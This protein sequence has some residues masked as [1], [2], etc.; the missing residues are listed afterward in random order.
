M[1]VTRRDVLE[2]AA[3]VVLAAPFVAFFVASGRQNREK[4]SRMRSRP[5]MTLRLATS[6]TEEIGATPRGTLSIFPVTGG[7]FDGNRLRGRVLAGG[8]D[9]VTTRA[10]GVIEVDLRVTLE[11]DDG[12]LIHMTFTGVR[13]DGHEYFRTLPRFE[14]AAPQYAFLNRLLAVGIGEIRDEGPAH[15]IEEVL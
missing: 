7:S 6:A 5:L 12:A 4:E 3:V 14:T 2:S 15:V 1:H 8:G 13:D 10:D 11:T 9:W